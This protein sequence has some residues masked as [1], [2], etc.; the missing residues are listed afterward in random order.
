MSRKNHK[1]KY[2]K[3]AHEKA[4]RVWVETGGNMSRV[5][6][7]IGCSYPTPSKWY[8]EDYPC[9][10]KCPWHGWPKIKEQ[11]DAAAQ[12]KAELFA[13]GN[14]NPIDHA[15]AMQQVLEDLPTD[16]R[17]IIMDLIR[18]DEEILGHWELLYGKVFF[19]LTGVPLA[20]SQVK[21]PQ[22]GDLMKIQTIY[23][24]G[25]QVQNMESG[26]RALASIRNEI[27]KLKIR[28]GLLK[29]VG[30]AKTAEELGQDNTGKDKPLTLEQIRQ[31]L[32]SVKSA[33]PEQMAALQKAQQPI[34]P[35]TP[36]TPAADFPPP[37][38][39]VQ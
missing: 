29:P 27:D 18:K 13:A 22:T 16:R 33:T 3:E 19:H 37:P 32:D 30:M 4:Y 28:N 11:E 24:E 35:I 9:L 8:Q 23:G 12:R 34:A 39:T 25:L 38:V 10:E 17:E 5:A 26:I 15:M 36:P 14:Y 31:T 6:D 7:A 2:G 20:F 1:L 21:N